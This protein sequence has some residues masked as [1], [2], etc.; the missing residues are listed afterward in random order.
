MKQELEKLLRE[1]NVENDELNELLSYVLDEPIFL[2]SEKRLLS[3]QEI[4]NYK[5]ELKCDV[6][7]IPLIDQ[8]DNNF[9]I[10]NLETNQFQMFDISENKSWKNLESIQE[11]LNLLEKHD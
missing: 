11:Y 9:L 10:Y 8:Y 6:D 3:L 7:M 4:L 5:E 1:K 2:E